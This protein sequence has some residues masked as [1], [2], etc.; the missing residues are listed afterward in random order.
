MRSN[1]QK[2][3]ET[4]LNVARQLAVAVGAMGVLL[5]VLVSSV[6]LHADPVLITYGCEARPT[7]GDDDYTQVIYLSVP[8]DSEQRLYLRCVLIG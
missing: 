7:E 2:P 6:R 1:S 5:L 8:A 4:C 3:V